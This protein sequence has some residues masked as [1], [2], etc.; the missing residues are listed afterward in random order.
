MKL[1]EVAAAE[2]NLAEACAEALQAAKLYT[3][4]GAL[5]QAQQAFEQWSE[6]QPTG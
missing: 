2:G 1:S 5:R 3:E 6:L 4:A